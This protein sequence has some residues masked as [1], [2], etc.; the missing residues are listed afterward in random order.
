MKYKYENLGFRRVNSSGSL[1][2]VLKHVARCSSNKRTFSYK[3]SFAC[4]YLYW[5]CWWAAWSTSEICLANRFFLKKKKYCI[6]V[7]H[8]A[9]QYSVKI[10]FIGHEMI[11]QALKYSWSGWKNYYIGIYLRQAKSLFISRFK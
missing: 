9:C 7:N 8:E 5:T 4:V 6:P 11:F 1:R 10:I 3:L 2:P